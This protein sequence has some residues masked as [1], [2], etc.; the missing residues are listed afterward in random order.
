MVKSIQYFKN[1]YNIDKDILN[2]QKNVIIVLYKEEGNMKQ[3]I[4]NNFISIVGL[5]MLLVFLIPDK[6]NNK[7]QRILFFLIVILVTVELIFANIDLY[8]SFRES[9]TPWR[10]FTSAVGYT[11][12]P[13]IAYVVLGLTFNLTK[14]EKLYEWLCLPLLINTL[15]SFSVFFCKWCFYFT[16]DNHWQSGTV[17]PQFSYF[18]ISFYIGMILIDNII[19]IKVKNV[20][21]SFVTLIG[22]L[23]VVCGM[24]FESKFSIFGVSR[25]SV[26]LAVIFFFLF[27]QS[28]IYYN[29]IDAIQYLARHDG[30]TGVYNRYAF[31]VFCEELKN[32]SSPLGFLILD[33]DYFKEINDQYGHVTG[34]LVLKKVANNLS[35]L[36]H[37]FRIIRFGGDEFVVLLENLSIEDSNFVISKIVELNK[38]LM[39]SKNN[40]MPSVSVSAGLAFSNQGYDE[41]LYANAD[42]AL[43]QRKNSNRRGC[44]LFEVEK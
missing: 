8:L 18:F 43:Y 37:G 13:M 1:G 14:H 3:F 40:K 10:L 30:L 22:T 7:K 21:F 33:V 27:Y 19:N 44:T 35:T 38:T 41:S 28:K 9:F 4:L 42:K 5:I 34:D 26:I 29:D 15:C 20:F 25:S 32:S 31:D 2:K 16:E 36:F 39:M 6:S 11:V 12:R 17:F 24:I 23:I